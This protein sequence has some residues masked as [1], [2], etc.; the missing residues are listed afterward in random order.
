[1]QQ[2]D[3][4]AGVYAGFSFGLFFVPKNNFFAI[5]KKYI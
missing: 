3:V 1:M 4:G 5:F 2:V